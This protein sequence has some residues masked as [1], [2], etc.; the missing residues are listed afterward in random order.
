MQDHEKTKEQLA[1][2]KLAKEKKEALV[3]KAREKITQEEAKELNRLLDKV[4]G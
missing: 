3:E 1:K 4:R 2:D